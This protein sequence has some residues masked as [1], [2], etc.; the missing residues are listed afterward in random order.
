MSIESFIKRITKDTAVYW[1]AP[2][3]ATDGSNDFGTPVEIKCLWK[4]EA[5]MSK[6]NAGTE[7]LSTALIYVNEDLDEQGML[8]HGSLADLTTAEKN[9]PSKVKNASVIRIFMKTP[10][11]HIKNQH[12]RRA[13]I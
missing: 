4:H 1:A 5:V 12:S 10:S 9:D 2:V 6:D 7:V 8:Y 13:M 11:L 3:A